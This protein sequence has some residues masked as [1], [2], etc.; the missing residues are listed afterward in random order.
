[1]TP[2]RLFRWVLRGV[3]WSRAPALTFQGGST[4]V[5]SDI[6]TDATGGSVHA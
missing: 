5:Q 6:A 3:E 4:K 2:L 1:M